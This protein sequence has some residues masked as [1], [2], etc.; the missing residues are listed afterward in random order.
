MRH[1]ARRAIL[2]VIGYF[3][4][5]YVLPLIFSVFGIPLPSNAVQLI[6]I[7][8]AIVALGYIVYG[9]PVPWGA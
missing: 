7:L 8:A 6:R 9:P 2:A 3:I 4:F 1:W 5:I